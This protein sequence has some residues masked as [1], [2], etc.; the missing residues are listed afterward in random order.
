MPYVRKYGL[1]RDRVSVDD[2]FSDESIIKK[3]TPLM[4]PNENEIFNDRRISVLLCI[5]FHICYNTFQTEAC[6]I[7]TSILY[8]LSENYWNIP[9]FLIVTLRRLV[10]MKTKL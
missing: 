1:N 10:K 5:L 7:T 3:I 8:H 6:F 4:A 9:K 2:V